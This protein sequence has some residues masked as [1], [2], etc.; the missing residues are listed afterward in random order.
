MLCL[1]LSL[2]LNLTLATPERNTRISPSFEASDLPLPFLG[3]QESVEV[4]FEV[5]TLDKIASFRILKVTFPIV[6]GS[7]YS[8]TSLK[9][10]VRRP[11]PFASALGSNMVGVGMDGED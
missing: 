2:S 11:K 6:W 1:N 5:L 7:T 9:T 3:S 10:L 4:T 8:S